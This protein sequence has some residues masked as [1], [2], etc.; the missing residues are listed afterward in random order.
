MQ[1]SKQFVICSLLLGDLVIIW[2]LYL[3][4]CKRESSLYAL[5]NLLL[6]AQARCGRSWGA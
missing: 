1:V 5:T 6:C 3:G 4:S 2:C